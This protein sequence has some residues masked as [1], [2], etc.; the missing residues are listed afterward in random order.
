MVLT[1]QTLLVVMNTPL[2]LLA[3]KFIM[4]QAQKSGL[5]INAGQS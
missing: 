1:D 5:T 4:D 2:E 3:I